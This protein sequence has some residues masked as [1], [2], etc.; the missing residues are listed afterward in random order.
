MM[1]L[2]VVMMAAFM[3]VVMAVLTMVLRFHVS[4]WL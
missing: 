2:V 1:L 4:G 3:T